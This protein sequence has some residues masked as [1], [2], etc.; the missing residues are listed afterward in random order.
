MDKFVEKNC[1]LDAPQVKTQGDILFISLLGDQM[2]G[3]RS[4]VQ[5][6][7]IPEGT[8]LSGDK[9]ICVTEQVMF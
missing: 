8:V 2:Q 1:N 6:E 9:C 3:P 5:K 7:E 4:E